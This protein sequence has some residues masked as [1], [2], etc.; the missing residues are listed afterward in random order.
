MILLTAVPRWRQPPRDVGGAPLWPSGARCSAGPGRTARWARAKP[1]RCVSRAC[2]WAE[3]GQAATWRPLASAGARHFR[4]PA[5][6]KKREE[7]G[8]RGG[9]TSWPAVRFRPGGMSRLN[10]FGHCS[11]RP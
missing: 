5:T 4:A 1:G 11:R 2:S 8:A 9:Y 3:R 7:F 10:V 6:P